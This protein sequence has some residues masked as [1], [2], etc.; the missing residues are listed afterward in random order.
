MKAE[1]VTFVRAYNYGAVLQCYALAR[2]LESI[3]IQPEVLDYNPQ[4]FQSEYRMWDEVW[5]GR[6]FL[7]VRRWLLR[8]YGWMLNRIRCRRFNRFLERQMPLSGKTYN[9]I[10]ELQTAEL[11]CDCYIAGSDQIWH[12]GCSRFD[13]VFFLDF[14]DAQRKERFSYAAS[15]GHGEIPEQLESEYRR[16]LS[17]FSRY[18]VRESSGAEILEDLL[19]EKAEV[20]CDPTLLLREEEWAQ[21]GKRKTKRRPYILVYYVTK[22]QKLQQYAKK[23]AQQKKMKVICVPC[24]MT[25]EVL[26]GRLDKQYG[27]DFKS[28]CSP[29]DFVGLLRDAAYVVTNSF[30]GTVFSILFHKKFV[31]QTV[32]D[33]GREN[34]RACN[35]MQAL[36]IQNRELQENVDIDAVLPWDEID[37]KRETIRRRAL[38][39]LESINRGNEYATGQ[40]DCTCL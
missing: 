29:E 23:L 9:S 10:E 28:T 13:P 24:H 2:T 37:K 11:E 40:R 12:A 26:T 17:G 7:P 22:T 8:V 19:G 1:I 5:L 38:N 14:P 16:R 18:S 25:L 33:D 4:Y 35:L 32:L 34:T 27:F 30:H 15:F 20:C 3:G 31:V 36:G 21:L 39:Y 6:P